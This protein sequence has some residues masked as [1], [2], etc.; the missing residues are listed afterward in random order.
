MASAFGDLPVVQSAFGVRP[1]MTWR[2]CG[3]ADAH[4][5]DYMLVHSQEAKKFDPDGNYVRRWLPVLGRMPAKWIHRCC[6]ARRCIPC[7]YTYEEESGHFGQDISE[8]QT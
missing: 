4:S 2:S 5:F 6:L 1:D 3:C 7:G 8:E